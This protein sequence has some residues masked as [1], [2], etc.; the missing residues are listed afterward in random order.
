MLTK[1]HLQTLTNAIKHSLYYA[2]HQNIACEVGATINLGLSVNV[3]MQQVDTIEFN[4]NQKLSITV[5]F[6]QHQGTVT[7]TELTKQAIEDAIIKA[8]SIALFP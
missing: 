6:N 8:K 4:N 5:Y 1:D 7:I 2:K 3:R